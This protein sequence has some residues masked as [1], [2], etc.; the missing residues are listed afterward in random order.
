MRSYTAYY[1][2][3]EQDFYDMQQQLLRA[4]VVVTQIAEKALMAD[5]QSRMLDT[6]DVVRSVLDAVSLLGQATSDL[7]NKRK[8]NLRLILCPDVRTVCSSELEVSTHLFGEDLG[9][10]LKEAREI[11]KVSSS[12][13][14][15]KDYVARN[16]TNN[17][18]TSSRT[19]GYPSKSSSTVSHKPSPKQKQSFLERGKRQHKRR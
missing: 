16:S 15:K 13:A 17:S 10:S 1:Q 2:R 18:Y 7:S 3:N 11:S 8:A 14:S 12:Y 5:Q 6:K 4:N 19:Y 9:K